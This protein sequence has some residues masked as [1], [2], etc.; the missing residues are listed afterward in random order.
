MHLRKDAVS[1]TNTAAAKPKPQSKPVA[2]ND[3]EEF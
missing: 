2:S 1:S 3:W